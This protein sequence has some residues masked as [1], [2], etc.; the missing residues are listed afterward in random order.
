MINAE[1]LELHPD[2]EPK[3]GTPSALSPWGELF[4]PLAGLVDVAAERTRLEKE[5]A[6]AEADVAAAS[7]Q[8][9]NP[10]FIARA[11]VEKVA[12]HRA[13]L[14]ETEAR[15]VKLRAMVAALG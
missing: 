4:M 5:I 15:L 13:R 1:D 2:Y 11:P 12:E 3:R 10:N 6:K 14:A 7:R 8:L 9:E